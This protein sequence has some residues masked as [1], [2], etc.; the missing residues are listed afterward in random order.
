[1]EH[2]I[3]HSILIVEDEPLLRID[4]VDMMEDEGFNTLEAAS[5]DTALLLLESDKAIT[6]LCTDIDMP[7]SMDGL[8]LA[9][10]VR[11]R[12]PKVA[13]VVASGHHHPDETEL[14]DRSRFVPKPYSRSAI[15]DAL[16]AATSI[17]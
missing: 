15:L 1:M 12:W 17:I 5:A 11:Q 4:I 16:K 10:I 14:P 13:I 6:V 2:V 9:Q 7:G 3:R 8:A